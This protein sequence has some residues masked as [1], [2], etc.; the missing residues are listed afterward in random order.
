[1]T[2]N[3]LDISYIK[4]ITSKYFP[5]ERAKK[6]RVMVIDDN[7]DTLGIIRLILGR[8][9]LNVTISNTAKH[10]YDLKAEDYPDLFIIDINLKDADGRDLC[11]A[12]KENPNTEHI[13]VILYTGASLHD[14][15]SY[16]KMCIPD[17]V[18]SKP[19]TV[20]DLTDNI[21]KLLV[22]E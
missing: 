17:C 14:L 7:E 11:V 12:L 3:I 9:D 4:D 15:K 18:L 1:M 2:Q 22:K 19:F 20:G 13:P 5:K 8:N 6:K 21:V 10:F 16:N